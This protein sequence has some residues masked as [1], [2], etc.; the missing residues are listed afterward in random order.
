MKDNFKKRSNVSGPKIRSDGKS[1]NLHSFEI[2]DSTIF[3]NILLLVLKILGIKMVD[4]ALSW[5]YVRIYYSHYNQVH[6]K[7]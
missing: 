6:A 7:L 1:E 3:Q 4:I 5:H 2:K